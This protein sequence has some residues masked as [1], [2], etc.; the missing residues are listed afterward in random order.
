M[1]G[2]PRWID[3]VLEGPDVAMVFFIVLKGTASRQTS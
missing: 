1:M 3:T 2:Y